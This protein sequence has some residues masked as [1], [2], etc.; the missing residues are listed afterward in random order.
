M[1]AIGSDHLMRAAILMSIFVLVAALSMHYVVAVNRMP[2]RSDP[3][4]SLD[5]YSQF[6]PPRPEAISETDARVS[7]SDD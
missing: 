5:A 6:Q 2:E 4:V 1:T 7:L 3:L